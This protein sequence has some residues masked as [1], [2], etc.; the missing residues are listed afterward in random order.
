MY[1][2]YIIIYYVHIKMMICIYIYAL[3]TTTLNGDVYHQ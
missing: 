1:N 2:M 3:Y